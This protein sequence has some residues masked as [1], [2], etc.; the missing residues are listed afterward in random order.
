MHS[1]G[2]TPIAS[3]AS[4]PISRSIGASIGSGH[5]ETATPLS[6]GRQESCQAPSAF[7]AAR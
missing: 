7:L 3:N 2:Q 1:I 4:V 5:E 6:L